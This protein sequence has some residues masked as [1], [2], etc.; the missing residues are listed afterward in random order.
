MLPQTYEEYCKTYNRSLKE[1]PAES[2]HNVKGCHGALQISNLARVRKIKNGVVTIIVPHLDNYGYLR[3]RFSRQ[4]KKMLFQVHRLMAEIFVP[5]PAGKPEVDHINGNKLDCRIENLRWVTHAENMKHA[6]E[7]GLMKSGEDNHSAKLTNLQARIVYELTQTTKLSNSE[8]GLAFNVSSE[9]VRKIRHRLTYK[10]ALPPVVPV[11]TSELVFIQNNQVL[12]DSRIVAAYFGK[13]HKNVL[14]DIRDLIEQIN[15][16]K[17]EPVA[18]ALKFEEVANAPNFG[19]VK[20][21]EESSYV[22]KKGETRPMYLMNRDGFMLLV[23]GFTGKKAL[24]FKLAFIQEFNRME[25]IL[26]S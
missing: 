22:D 21:F 10:V 13:D 9:I 18:N 4:G 3:I 14:R 6:A 11:P 12:T 5:N 25:K 19:L 2:W 26:K 24:Q 17:N 23:M 15:R 8:I 20:M 1:N 7:L 16:L